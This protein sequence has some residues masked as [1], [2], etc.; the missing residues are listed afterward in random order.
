MSRAAAALALA[1]LLLNSELARGALRGGKNKQ[2]HE[3]EVNAEG[4]LPGD[5]RRGLQEQHEAQPRF[6]AYYPAS[7]EADVV[8]VE[9]LAQVDAFA[10]S[11]GWLAEYT[12]V[13]N[14]GK[15]QLSDFGSILC[16]FTPGDLV[17]FQVHGALEAHVTGLRGGFASV[18]CTP[19]Y[20]TKDTW[21]WYTSLLLASTTGEA[22]EQ[23][24][25]VFV[26]DGAHAASK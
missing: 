3:F 12:A 10:L 9:A 19:T 24:A 15:W 26:E 5:A 14:L 21:P 16:L 1:F 4:R 8:L 7:L 13:E 22:G 6:L 23:E 2:N 25:I 18:G 17:P 20:D 11:R